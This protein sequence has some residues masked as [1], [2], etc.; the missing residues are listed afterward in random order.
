[1]TNWQSTKLVK[2]ISKFTVDTVQWRRPIDQSAISVWKKTFFCFYWSTM[3]WSS[4][5]RPIFE[6]RSDLTSIVLEISSIQR[7]MFMFLFSCIMNDITRLALHSYAYIMSGF[8]WIFMN[9]AKWVTSPDIIDH[10]RCLKLAVTLF[11]SYPLSRLAAKRPHAAKHRLRTK[12]V[13]IRS[14]ESG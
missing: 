10:G 12:R 14:S 4:A 3:R 6:L 2:W 8:L 9:Y 11:Y 1:M 7:F 5:F 13:Y